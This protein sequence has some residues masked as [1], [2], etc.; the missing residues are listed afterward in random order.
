MILVIRDESNSDQN[1]SGVLIVQLQRDIQDLVPCIDL[2][3]S[4]ES[5]TNSVSS[6]SI[7]VPDL[8]LN[9]FRALLRESPVVPFPYW[10][11]PT[12]VVRLRLLLG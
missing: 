9:A 10:I 8:N 1:G 11:L 7:F 6:T 4:D 2:T 3:K 5:M 12:T